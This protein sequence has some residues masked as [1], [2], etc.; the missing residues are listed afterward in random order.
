MESLFA[1]ICPDLTGLL[2]KR[3]DP[4]NGCIVGIEDAGSEVKADIACQLFA[5]FVDEIGSGRHEAILIPT[6]IKINAE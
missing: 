5:Y 6:L 1:I 4:I 3:L 2:H